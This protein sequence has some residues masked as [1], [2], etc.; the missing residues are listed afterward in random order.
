MYAWHG[1]QRSLSEQLS[2]REGASEHPT[3]KERACECPSYKVIA[4]VGSR[5]RTGATVVDMT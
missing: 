4:S 3:A 1:W 5:A 2:S